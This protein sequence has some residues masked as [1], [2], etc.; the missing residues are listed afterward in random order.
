MW[1]RA[2]ILQNILG[3]HF[4]WGHSICW[5]WPLIWKMPI[6]GISGIYFLL[7]QISLFLHKNQ[8]KQIKMTLHNFHEPTAFRCDSII[9]FHAHHWLC[10]ASNIW[11][12]LFPTV[13]TWGSLWSSN[14]LL[15]PCNYMFRSELNYGVRSYAPLR[16]GGIIGPQQD[17]NKCTCLLQTIS[18]SPIH[19]TH[20]SVLCVLLV[21]AKWSNCIVLYVI[22]MVIVACV[23]ALFVISSI[24]INI[25]STPM[26]LLPG[27][28]TL[29]VSLFQQNN[30]CW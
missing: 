14:C 20:P 18:S 3:S 24:N 28:I 6:W 30:C 16:P 19:I 5:K 10:N 9:Y 8:E 1:H 15:R 7:H 25:R 2:D 12:V 17:H 22:Y 26:I 21:H 27:R 11:P 23:A 13:T 4:E 29:V